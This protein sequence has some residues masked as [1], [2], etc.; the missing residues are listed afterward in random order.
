MGRDVAT[1]PFEQ[2][3]PTGSGAPIASSARIS[4]PVLAFAV[5]GYLLLAPPQFT[6]EIGGFVLPPYRVFLLGGFF[7]VLTAI[8]GGQ[9]KFRLPDTCIFLAAAWIAFALSMSMGVERAISGAGSQFVDIAVAYF[10]ARVAIKTPRD[11][12]MFLV[13]FAPG[14]GAIGG[15]IALESI[16]HSYIVQNIASAITGR[17]VVLPPIN[18]GNFR[19]G[20]LRAPGPFPHPILAGIFLGSFLSI[21]ALSGLRGWP[22]IAGIC[23][24]VFGFFS[25]SSAAILA[26]FVGSVLLAYNWISELIVNLGWR[27]FLMFAAITALTVEFSTNIGLFGFISRYLAMSSWNGFYRRLIWQFGSE[28]VQRNPLFGLGYAD[29][30]RL[31]WMTSSVDNYW[32]LLAMQYGLLPPFAIILAVIVTLVK[33]GRQSGSQALLD[34]RL[35]RGIAI[36]LAVF[37]LG[38]VS[39]AVWLEVQAWFFMLLGIAVSLGWQAQGPTRARS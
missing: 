17:P 19:L 32:L 10:F 15:L 31:E 16:S 14:L 30:A 18:G 4:G 38:L 26:I 2:P 21:Y 34:Q 3:H 24:A 13:L 29:W 8:L 5:L 39:V 7:Y 36:A 6:Q 12:R 35:L 28:S 22:R 33:V 9:L 20:L 11:L 37:A 27:I 1:V 23:A 25:I